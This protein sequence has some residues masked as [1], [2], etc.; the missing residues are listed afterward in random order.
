IALGKW[1]GFKGKIQRQEV[2]QHLRLKWQNLKHT[3]NI[4]N[5]NE[6]S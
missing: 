5:N 4:S 6:S 1:L 3:L 2:R